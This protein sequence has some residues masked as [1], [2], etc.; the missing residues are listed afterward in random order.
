MDD[1]MSSG[2]STNPM[3]DTLRFNDH[4][5]VVAWE[6]MTRGHA[7]L[8]EDD[9][10]LPWPPAGFV[11]CPRCG[12]GLLVL[13]RTTQ[14]EYYVHPDRM[15][16]PERQDKRGGDVHIDTVFCDNSACGAEWKTPKF[17]ARL[18]VERN[19]PPT[20]PG[21]VLYD[22]KNTSVLVC[23]LLGYLRDH[24]PNGHDRWLRSWPQLA[25]RLEQGGYPA[26]LHLFED[27]DPRFVDDAVSD[28]TSTLDHM[29]PEGHRFFFRDEPDGAWGYWPTEEEN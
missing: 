1:G 8:P 2:F 28:L 19:P 25:S 10:R 6:E 14:S 16:D 7:H 29:A 24:D 13:R 20:K 4:E 22:P 17:N 11:V 21:V 12:Q 9:E 23:M 15:W 27:L 3:E 18:G 5:S 26:R